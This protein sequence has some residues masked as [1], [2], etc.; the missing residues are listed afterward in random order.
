MSLR[1]TAV[2][3]GAFFACLP[4]VISA[5]VGDAPVQNPPPDGSTA[6][7][8]V[9]N[10]AGGVDQSAP[11]DAAPDAPPPCGAA[12]ETCCVAPLVPCNDGLSCTTNTKKCLAS[13]VWAVGEYKTY[14][15]NNGGFVTLIVT[16]HYDGATWTRGKDVLSDNALSAAYPVTIYQS[17]TSVRVVTNKSPNGAMWSWN[18]V[19]WQ[20]CKLGNACVGPT[21]TGYYWALTSV[22]NGGNRDFWLAGSN[23]MYRC[24]SGAS[25]CTSVMTGIPGNSVGSGHFAGDTAQDLWFTVLDHVI[26]YDGTQWSSTAVQDAIAIGEVAPND[27]W[28]GYKLLRH[29]DGKT[30]S[31]G[32]QIDGAAT[33]GLIFDIAAIASNDLWAVG[34][35]NTASFAAHWNGTD[36]KKTA[37]PPMNQ[38]A[39]IYAPSSSDVFVVGSKPTATN[40]GVIAHWDGTKWTEMPTPTLT[41]PQEQSAGTLKWVSISGAAR[42]R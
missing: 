26:H 36:W 24:A 3:A 29:Y 35:D 40:T 25:N 38:T 39:S 14:A 5:C 7:V 11:I 22:S 19:T 6:D 37:L 16:A 4:L 8:V 13:D 18:T 2:V 10:D 20:E 17:G 21:P 41:Y 42:K 1:S 23:Q 32:Y 28:V 30:W 15:P 34:N 31:N 33:P 9:P 12:G 27:V